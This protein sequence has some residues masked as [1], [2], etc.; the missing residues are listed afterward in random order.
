MEKLLT[1]IVPVYNGASYLEKC[2]TSFIDPSIEKELEV[3]VV[4]DG[5]EDATSEIADSFCKKYPLQ[6]RLEHKLNGMWR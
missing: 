5:S 6:F 1:I 3:I 2:L 4:D